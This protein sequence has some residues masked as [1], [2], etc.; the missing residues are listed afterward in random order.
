MFTTVGVVEVQPRLPHLSNSPLSGMARR[1]FGGKT[2]VEWIARRLSDSHWIDHV[3]IL[4]AGPQGA[5]LVQD[6]PADIQV[7]HAPAPDALG[8]LAHAVRET[9][10]RSV[11]RVNIT[12]P[13]VDPVLVDRLVTVA[14]ADGLC[15][16][17][18]FRLADG[19]PVMSTR[20]GVFAEWCNGAAVLKADKLAKSPADRCDST[21]F[22]LNRA[23]LF[24]IKL[25]GVPSGLE[26]DDLRLAVH[27]EED[28]EHLQLILDALGPDSLEW[29]RIAG[30]IDRQPHLRDRMAARNQSEASV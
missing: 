22:L 15:D 16:Y 4:T 9:S 17:A 25:L 13:F 28:W 2:L 23:D 10:A 20:L 11:V 24:N 5:A 26:R 3:V 30:L 18:T 29:Q 1:R 21:H 19:R 12:D 27:D 6:C 14:G 7:V 8:A